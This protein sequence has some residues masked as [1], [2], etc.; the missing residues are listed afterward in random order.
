[1]HE[2]LV[3]HDLEEERRDQGEDL[4]EERG[5]QDFAQQAAVLID[6]P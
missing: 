3:D 6:R 2:H 4:Q 5:D 1:V